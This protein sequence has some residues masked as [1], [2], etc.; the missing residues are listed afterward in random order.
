MRHS[1]IILSS[2]LMLA[3]CANEPKEAPVCNGNTLRGCKPVVYFAEGSS[4]LDWKGTENLI[5][6][7]RKMK[8]WPDRNVEIVGHASFSGAADR[9]LALSKERAL[10]AKKFLVTNGI[11]ENRIKIS[12]K[13]NQ[14]PVCKTDSCQALNRRVELDIAPAN[15]GWFREKLDNISCFLCE[16]KE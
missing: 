8:R 15:G 14:D 16:D 2:I 4:T 7:T 13:S 11:D 10:A 1:L 3:A 9:N 6:A 5:W 12:F